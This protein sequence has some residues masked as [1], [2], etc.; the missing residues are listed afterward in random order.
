MSAHRGRR[1]ALVFAHP[2]D[3]TF[4]TGATIARYARAG[5][6]IALFCA[7]DG[8]A[9]KSS[10]VPVASPQELAAIRRNELHAAARHLG[11]RD[12]IACGHPDGGL[13]GVDDEALIGDVV[14]FLRRVQPEVVV[15]F[16][17]EG[18]PTGHP[19]HRA[20]SRAATAAFFLAALP[21]EHEGTGQPH[22]AARLYYTTFYPPRPGARL[23]RLGL[24]P[25]ARLDAR[26]WEQRKREA[27]MLHATQRVHQS[28]FEELAM[29]P[30]EWFAL[31]SG[32]GQGEDVVGDL[33]DGL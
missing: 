28:T 21:T 25:T 30:E 8:G 7:T 11:I 26:P 9:G 12:V 5:V 3:E 32:A 17:P 19:D 15:T 10:D 27:F 22:R 6:H 33:F 14:R 13:A 16:G 1:L 18:A 4:A 31:A 20:I 24:P 2:D 23:Q 29:T